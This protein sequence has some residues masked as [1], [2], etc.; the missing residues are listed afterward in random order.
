MEVKLTARV[1]VS[2]ALYS[3]DR[4]YEYKIPSGLNEKLRPGMRVIV[5]FGRGNRKCEGFVLKI[6]ESSGAEKL[7]ALYSILDDEPVLDERQIRLGLWMRDRFF[8]TAYDALRVML[9]AGIWFQLKYFYALEDGMTFDMAREAVSGYELALKTLRVLEDHGGRAEDIAIKGLLGD[10]EARSTLKKLKDMGIIRQEAMESQRV[11][12]KMSQTARLTISAGQAAELAVRKKKNA[13]SQAAVLELLSR[14]YEADVKELC[15]FTG[16]SRTTIKR[17]AAMGAIELEPYE[18]FRNPEI[19]GRGTDGKTEL[20]DEQNRAFKGLMMLADRGDAS[21]ALLHGVTGS[22]KTLIYISLIHEMLHRDK[23]AIF[24]VPE[25]SLT[26]Q[27]AGEFVGRF[28]D[29]VAVLHSGLS[30]GERYDEWKRVKS[31]AARV[32]V[33]TRSAI[34]APV[35]DMGIIIIDEEQEYTYKSEN[36]PRYHARDVAKYRCHQSG[37]LL[38]LGSATPAIESMYNAKE[39]IY[40][41]FSLR[42]RYNEME[43]PRVII[44]DMK[45]N[46]RNGNN[47]SISNELKEEIEKNLEKSEQSILFINRRGTSNLIACGECGYTNTCPRCSVSLTYHGDNNRLMCH[48]CGFSRRQ[49]EECPECGGIMRHIGAGTQR[50]VEHLEEILPGVG[51]LRMDTDT[52]SGKNPHEKILGRFEDERI[53]ILVGTQMI[54]KGLNFENVTLVG[55]ISADQSLYTSDYKAQERTFSQITQV[56]GRAGRGGKKGRAVIQTYT[57]RNEVIRLAASQDY[58]GFYDQEIEFRRA[59]EVPPFCE[60]ISIVASGIDESCVFAC[61]SYI[62]RGLEV[63]LRDREDVTVLGPAAATVSKVNN[64]FRYKVTLKCKNDKMI[65]EAVS[66]VIRQ[67]S[68]K[69][70]FRRIAVYGDLGHFD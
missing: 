57:P 20:N 41:H 5:P 37:A 27:L 38:V 70:E 64:R 31:G 21:V 33:G 45:K 46:L 11:R 8:S 59:L 32:V 68:R 50:V 48:Y 43:L 40:Q 14:I 53:P 52:I 44:S 65:R 9:P 66:R 18:V 49:A 47:L 22:G 34:F 2:S 67:A 4:P 61:L 36:S 35:Q 69:N 25:I 1:A 19:K 29:K 30:M 55:V 24:L 6:G 10:N 42:T 16:A 23:S 54:T 39:G 51:V 63:Y 56:V 3:I 26:P 15:Y 17:L 13:S 60:I 58:D 7:K 12:D 28:G 62:R